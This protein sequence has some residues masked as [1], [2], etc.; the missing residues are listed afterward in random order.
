MVN[1]VQYMKKGLISVALIAG[2]LGFSGSAISSVIY[3]A[4]SAVCD[5]GCPG[6]G[7]LQDTIDQSGLFTGYVSGVTDFDAYIASDPQHS[8]VFA[9]NEWFS[10]LGTSAATVTYNLGSALAIDAI[11]LWNE[12]ASGITNLDLEVS[13]DGVN[14]SSLLSGLT[15]TD[16]PISLDYGA[17]V[18]SFGLVTTQYVRFKM[19]DCPQNSGEY[20]ACAIGEVAFRGLSVPEPAPLALMGFGLM[21]MIFS[22]RRKHVKLAGPLG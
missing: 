2:A 15:P 10:E 21:G 14:F 4:S 1:S 12:D 8:L 7:D 11:A 9:G 20:Q 13:L 17:E 22:Q 3:S 16:N 6:D 18:F 19:T 5:L